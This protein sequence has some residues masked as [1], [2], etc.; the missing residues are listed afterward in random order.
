[1]KQ[2]VTVLSL[3]GMYVCVF[4]R[5]AGSAWFRI[6]SLH[7]AFSGSLT[8]PTNGPQRHRDTG[9]VASTRL[10]SI[11][12]DEFLENNCSAAVGAERV[13]AVSVKDLTGPI[14]CYRMDLESHISFQVAGKPPAKS[15]LC[16]SVNDLSP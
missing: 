2:Y 11:D 5:F 14:P 8:V 9:T 15:Y 1:M 6:Q 7:F 4:R 12:C 3:Y 10:W 16:V 13:P